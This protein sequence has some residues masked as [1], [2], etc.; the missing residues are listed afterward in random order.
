MA[1]S[2]QASEAG[3]Q[4][5]KASL[6]CS[7]AEFAKTLEQ[8]MSEPTVK[9]FFQKTPIERKNF[10]EICRALNLDWQEIVDRE[11]GGL[12]PWIIS[13]DLFKNKKNRQVNLY[14]A[15]RGWIL[16]ILKP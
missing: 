4:K 12:C 10:V 13:E 5:A 16:G 3:L 1:R 14:P 8:K 6:Y 11:E 2:I 9:R 15:F 7:Q